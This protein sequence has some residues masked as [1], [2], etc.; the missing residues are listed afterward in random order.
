MGITSWKVKVKIGLVYDFSD[1]RTL[2]KYIN[3]GRVTNEDTIS[4]N[5][6]EWMTIGDI[7]DLD[8]HFI[9]VYKAAYAESAGNF[10]PTPESTE[11]GSLGADLANEAL[12]QITEEALADEDLY[13]DDVTP[14]AV[15]PQ[16]SD[17]F[18]ALKTRQDARLQSRQQQGVK[19]QKA[20]S[21]AR[22]AAVGRTGVLGVF[23]VLASVVYWMGKEPNLPL[24]VETETS[25]ESSAREN[26]RQTAADSL[27]AEIERKLELV[28]EPL[29]LE[30]FLQEEEQER[31][32]VIPTSPTTPGTNGAEVG[33]GANSGR[34]S[35]LVQS[36]SQVLQ[37]AQR[38]YQVGNFADAAENYVRAM[39]LG[40]S[41]A[42]IQAAYGK[43]LYK[44]G[45][46]A[47]ARSEMARAEKAGVRDRELLTFLVDSCHQL[48]DPGGANAY[49]V[50]LDE[51]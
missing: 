19:R 6:R 49:Q 42:R 43:T 20:A 4:H 17:P 44:L 22:M 28:D 29:P 8:G 24:P 45:R 15:G 37:E 25:T 39:A 26:A 33:P 27:R 3:D 7:P 34:N 13:T 12:R 35:N 30:E 32:A 1:L 51:L 47:E 48:G 41:G 46:Y 18:A 10:L 36:P 31:V 2:R 21:K 16:F 11:E 50:K 5:G 40:S 23:A 9:Q 38:A 14:A